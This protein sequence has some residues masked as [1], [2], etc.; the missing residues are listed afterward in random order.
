MD[1]EDE[2]VPLDQRALRVLRREG[3]FDSAWQV[4]AEQR[5]Q[6][7]R[8]GRRRRPVHTSPSASDRRGRARRRSGSRAAA[9][10]PSAPSRRPAAGGPGREPLRVRRSAT[11]GTTEKKRLVA[12]SSASEHA[13][14]RSV[15][16]LRPDRAAAE[17]DRR[18]GRHEERR[19]LDRDVRLVAAV[20]ELQPGQDAY[21]ERGGQGPRRPRSPAMRRPESIAR[22]RG[23]PFG[24]GP[25]ENVASGRTCRSDDATFD[26]RED[27]KPVCG[28]RQRNPRPPRGGSCSFPAGA[29]RATRRRRAG[30]D[31]RGLRRHHGGSADPRAPPRRGCDGPQHAAHGRHRRDERDHEG[32]APAGRPGADGLDDERRRARCDR[33]RRVRLPAEGRRRRRDRQRGAHRQGGQLDPLAADRRRRR[34]PGPRAERRRT[35]SPTTCSR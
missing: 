10:N 33:R 2:R 3:R 34:A 14:S 27:G 7:R 29:P 21:G 4:V 5:R 35:S 30:G 20:G 6:R 23:T 22:R 24:P 12:A 18:K 32:R 9:A 1:G 13:S 8:R 25:A 28:N 17:Q 19:S 16:D 31:R 11:A 26:L 15:R